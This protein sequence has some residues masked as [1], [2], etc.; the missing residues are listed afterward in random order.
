MG[1]FTLRAHAHGMGNTK[2]PSHHAERPSSATC[3]DAHEALN[4]RSCAVCDIVDKQEVT[5]KLRP[6]ATPRAPLAS[7]ET[8]Q[9]VGAGLLAT[10]AGFG[11]A[12]AVL[13]CRRG[14]QRQPKTDCE[15]YSTGFATRRLRLVPA[16]RRDPK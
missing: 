7:A 14:C 13:A 11:A 3:A 6:P 4:R 2:H 9:L 5:P 12:A 10:A 1:A 15:S 16:A 8:A